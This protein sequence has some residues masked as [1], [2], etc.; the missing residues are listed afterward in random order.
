[1]DLNFISSLC[2]ASEEWK[3]IPLTYKVASGKEKTAQILR[4][5]TGINGVFVICEGK[6]D[7]PDIYSA[8]YH[9]LGIRNSLFCF[10][11]TEGEAGGALYDPSQQ[12]FIEIVDFVI[13]FESFYFNHLI[14]Q[15]ELHLYDFKNLEDYLKV[16]IPEIEEVPKEEDDRREKYVRPLIS[17]EKLDH[18]ADIL[19]EMEG[20]AL[21]D[22][23]Y[24]V[25]SDGSMKVKKIISASN[26]VGI[27]VLSGSVSKHL[28]PC[29]EVDGNKAYITTLAGGWFGLHKFQRGKWGQGLLYLLTC[30]VG[31]VFYVYD[32]IMMLI[33]NYYD[34][35]VEYS[36]VEGHI[37]QK[38]QRVYARPVRNKRIW[39]LTVP[40]AMLFTWAV[41]TFVYI[42]TAQ[43][44]TTAIT[45]IVQDVAEDN[46]GSPIDGGSGAMDDY[47]TIPEN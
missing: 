11:W 43:A 8:L 46:L 32:L 14:P 29:E 21:V 7:M 23:N 33:G 19:L 44:I 42:P 13:G 20:A 9:R 34:T 39:A 45:T 12:S 10:V 47:I 41:T 30:G 5:M 3:D 16:Q 31:G 17:E 26:G 36:M 22:G 1:M 2:V 28:F 27:P 24:L 37:T 18:I 40:V 4:I 38:K 15:S 6:K 25:D 35:K